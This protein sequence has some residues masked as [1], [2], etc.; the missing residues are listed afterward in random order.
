MHDENVSIVD[1]ESGIL[2]S[3]LLEEDEEADTVDMITSFCL[4]PNGSEVVVALR[5]FLL[6]HYRIGEKEPVRTI[7]GHQMPVVAMDYDATGTL[8]ATGSADK[9]VRVWDIPRGH[10]THSFREHSDVVQLVQFHPDPT[11]L[12]LF[13]GSDD[14]TLRMYDLRKSTCIACFRQHMSLPTAISFSE[15]GNLMTSC[16]RDQVL[17]FYSIKSKP[18]HLKTVPVMDE[19]ESVV[20]LSPAHSAAILGAVKPVAGK[21]RSRESDSVDHVLVTGGIKGI[22]R[23]FKVTCE[24]ASLHSPF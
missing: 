4:H 8:V 23:V 5:N 16:G 9:T 24:V 6:R 1:W 21:K 19:L 12:V 22:L 10:C 11:R 18:E 17:N 20:L 15:D 14:S 7:R 13:S 3:R 2:S